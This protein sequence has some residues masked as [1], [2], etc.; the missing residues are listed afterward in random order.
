MFVLT[1]APIDIWSLLNWLRLWKLRATKYYMASK[2]DGY[3]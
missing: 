1:V 3:P 2:V